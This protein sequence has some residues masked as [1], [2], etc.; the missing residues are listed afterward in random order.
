MRLVKIVGGLLL[1]M[2]GGVGVVVVL[3]RAL[4]G[5]TFCLLYDTRDDTG[6][7]VR[8]IDPAV[9]KQFL[10]IHSPAQ[11]PVFP[12]NGDVSLDNKYAI[13]LTGPKNGPYSFYIDAAPLRAHDGY[14]HCFT[15]AGCWIGETPPHSGARLLASGVQQQHFVAAW[16]DSA[17][18]VHSTPVNDQQQTL[19]I[20]TPDSKTKYTLPMTFSQADEFTLTALDMP[21]IFLVNNRDIYVWYPDEKRVVSF[22]AVFSG[23]FDFPH[24]SPE[25]K[26][27][28]FVDQGKFVVLST[29]THTRTEI[30]LPSS[31][32]R[33][34]AFSWSPDERHFV[35]Q[36]QDSAT[37]WHSALYRLDG[38]KV[39]ELDGS[40]FWSTD[41]RIHY[42]PSSTGP[43]SYK[44]I[45]L[46]VDDGHSETLK[47]DVTWYQEQ[48]APGWIAL[49]WMENRKLM[50][51]TLDLQTGRLRAIS[52]DISQLGSVRPVNNGEAVLY[53][54]AHG[55]QYSTEVVDKDGN[56]RIVLFSGPWM[57][58][59]L[60][61]NAGKALLYIAEHNG[62]FNL[63]TID[64]DGT[65]HRVLV[66]GLDAVFNMSAWKDFN[67]L[68]AM[69]ESPDL[70]TF[71]GRRNGGLTAEIVNPQSGQ[72]RILADGL[73]G[74]DNL[75]VN[76]NISGVSFYWQ[77]AK[78]DSGVDGFSLDGQRVYH[79]T[80]PGQLYPGDSSIYTYALSP[81]KHV[82]AVVE[83]DPSRLHFIA[84]DSSWQKTVDVNL[85]YS[86]SQAW[87]PDGS[88]YAFVETDNVTSEI[89]VIVVDEN[90]DNAHRITGLGN[91]GRLSWNHCGY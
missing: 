86:S 89:S 16:I 43:H 78:D 79:V 75:A 70:I 69:H 58:E 29:S 81:N 14:G 5:Q 8:V 12:H 27:V 41:S 62:T 77:N 32:S 26:Y 53:T 87:S 1:V 50:L 71:I 10:Y 30:S 61:M 22:P 17:W 90:G 42:F 80:F 39:S 66:S 52:N 59:P 31:Q 82:V 74:I 20:E 46:Y 11:L 47:D 68:D 35:L 88:Q 2:I 38:S 28:T 4:Q 3:A 45:A 56:N 40:G 44:L 72:H 15:S 18:L 36:Y 13:Y 9:A 65:D 48:F 60:L 64:L 24:L 63:E 85:G 19:V 55:D 57:G 25:G 84:A 33:A 67:Y 73:K 7:E 34:V 54:V 51:G 91:A 37:N 76:P 6:G 83:L 21:L 23:Q 49:A